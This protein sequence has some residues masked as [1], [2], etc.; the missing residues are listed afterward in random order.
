MCTYILMLIQ[1]INFSKIHLTLRLINS[2]NHP[3]WKNPLRSSSPTIPTMLALSKVFLLGQLLMFKLNEL[4]VNLSFGAYIPCMCMCRQLVRTP[5]V[6]Q[7]TSVLSLVETQL[8]PCQGLPLIPTSRKLPTHHHPAWSSLVIT[9]ALTPTFISSSH[10]Q[11]GHTCPLPHGLTPTA[12]FAY[13]ANLVQSLHQQI[14]LHSVSHFLKFTKASAAD[15][16]TLEA[17]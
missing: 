7:P 3:G 14:K 15:L 11:H 1:N 2:Q 17:S 16:P 8:L 12:A 13:G 9:V 10:Q 5:P 6:P 4:K